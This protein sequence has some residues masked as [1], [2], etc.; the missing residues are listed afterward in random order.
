MRQLELMADRQCE[1][2]AK[3]SVWSRFAGA[4]ARQW[5]QAHRRM[6]LRATARTLH[7]LSDRT[8]HDIGIGRGEI[9][10]LVD[11]LDGDR[12]TSHYDGDARRWL[13]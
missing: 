12:R 7:G 13:Q 6:M 2:P 1:R 5:H 4:A 10:A 9:D 8:L 11:A 3:A